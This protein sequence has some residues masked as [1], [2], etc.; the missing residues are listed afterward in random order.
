MGRFCELL[1]PSPLEG[2]GASECPICFQA[3]GET[4][5]GRAWVESLSPSVIT[6][7]GVRALVKMRCHPHRVAPPVNPVCE[8]V[9]PGGGVGGQA[10]GRGGFARAG[11]LR[12][13]WDSQRDRHPR[14][15]Y[16]S[17][18]FILSRCQLGTFSSSLLELPEPTQPGWARDC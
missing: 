15:I 16:S 2:S 7:G 12:G 18:D 1:R 14:G 6:A 8:G 10:A 13:S 3:H 5:A 9:C 17:R 11:H 4:E